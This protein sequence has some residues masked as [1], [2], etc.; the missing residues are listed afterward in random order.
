MTNQ[1]IQAIDRNIKEAKATLEIGN[2]LERLRGNKDFKKIV[3]EGYFR[4]E[5][6]RLVHLKSDPSMQTPEYQKSII[7]QMDAIGALNQYFT[8]LVHQAGLAAKSIASDEEALEELLAE[9]AE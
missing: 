8:T 3:M 2:A 6:V 5:A 7:T 1:A 9:G 4:D